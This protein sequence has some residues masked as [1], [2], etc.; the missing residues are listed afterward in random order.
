MRI[1]DVREDG[2]VDVEV[3]VETRRADHG[4][5]VEARLQNAGF[6]VRS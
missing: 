2:S 5:E 6:V 4:V 1:F 3:L